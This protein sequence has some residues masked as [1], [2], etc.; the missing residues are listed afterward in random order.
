VGGDD[1]ETRSAS[2]LAYV[3]PLTHEDPA[4]R[5]VLSGRAQPSAPLQQ[6]DYYGH[7][8]QNYT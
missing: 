3:A 1:G 7:L 6:L 8:P 4:H 5:V 2:T